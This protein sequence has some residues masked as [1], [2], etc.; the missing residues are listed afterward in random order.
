M[1]EIAVA[2]LHTDAIL[3]TR[4]HRDDAGMDFYAL[5]N[6]VI[7]PNSV[8]IVYTGITVDWPQGYMGLAKPKGKHNYLL[9]AGVIDAGYQGEM[10]FKVF[11]PLM[12]NIIIRSGE[13]V[14][15]VVILPVV[16]PNILVEDIDKIH[17]ETT[18]RG[19]SGG[20]HN[21]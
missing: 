2:R 4:N 5:G 9:G 1:D 20:I 12:D 8:K 3:P 10:V 21:S 6:Y 19:T 7:L 18:A 14:A 16:I 15:Q 11:N 13:A 17:R